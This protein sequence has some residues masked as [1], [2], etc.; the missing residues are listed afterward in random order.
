MTFV[1]PSAAS[2]P[3]ARSSSL[4]L[5]ALLPLLTLP[6]LLT[7]EA[8]GWGLV[9]LASSTIAFSTRNQEAPRVEAIGEAGAVDL[10]LVMGFGGTLL[11]PSS[12]SLTSL[13]LPS[14]SCE[15]CDPPCSSSGSVARGVARIDFVS[16]SFLCVFFLV[17]FFVLVFGCCFLFL[18][19]FCFVFLFLFL[20]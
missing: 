16:W 9:E 14:L 19:L 4:P 1:P 10:W 13:S 17:F 2:S 8:D 6:M 20:I 12:L 3:L 5:L 15:P 7:L 18:F 11:A